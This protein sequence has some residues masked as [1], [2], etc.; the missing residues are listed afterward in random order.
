MWIRSRVE[1]LVIGRLITP[2]LSPILNG[3]LVIQRFTKARYDL[4]GLQ[5]IL[6][7]GITA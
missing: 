7:L 4:L 6:T 3:P 1:G 5:L 2:K